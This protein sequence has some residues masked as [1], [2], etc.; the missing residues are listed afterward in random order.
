MKKLLSLYR[1]YFLGPILRKINIRWAL[2]VGAVTVCALVAA[3]ANPEFFNE[4]PEA[5]ERFVG[6]DFSG[7]NPDDEAAAR[8]IHNPDA[9]IENWKRQKSAAELAADALSAFA[10]TNPVAFAR[11]YPVYK[12][13]A[14]LE[15]EAQADFAIR[16]PEKYRELINQ[17][18]TS[19]QFQ[20]EETSRWIITHPDE[21]NRMVHQVKTQQELAEDEAVGAAAHNPPATK[22]ARVYQSVP[23]RGETQP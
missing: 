17:T 21:F 18:K 7:M 13:P 12:S 5:V 23:L 15:A 20:D 2:A 14:Q 10:V 1:S 22:P 16:N 11:Q 9:S 19:Q 8:L 4:I 6:W 3:E